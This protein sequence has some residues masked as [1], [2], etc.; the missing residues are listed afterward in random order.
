ML[1]GLDENDPRAVANMGK[2][3]RPNHG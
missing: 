2:T 1:A 3:T